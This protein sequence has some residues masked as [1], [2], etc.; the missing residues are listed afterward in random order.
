KLRNVIA[1]FLGFLLCES[2]T[3]SSA[4]THE[5][6]TKLIFNSERILLFKNN[7]AIMRTCFSCKGIA[8]HYTE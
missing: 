6:S 5:K 4:K 2:C 3:N 8:F 1:A 7:D